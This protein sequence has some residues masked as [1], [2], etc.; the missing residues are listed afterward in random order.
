[1][2]EPASTLSSCYIK[3]MNVSIFIW[4]IYALWIILVAYLTVAAI[5]VKQAYYE[6]LEERFG[7][8]FIIIAAFL[9]PHLPIFNILNFTPDP[10]V[11]IIGVI[12]CIVGMV[13]LTWGRQSLGMNWSPTVA[14][15]KGQKLVTTG[16]Y[17]FVRN[18]IYSG[19]L[20]AA[21]GSAIVVG[22]AFIFLLIFLTPLF[23]WRVGAEDKLMEQQFSK[24]FSK[25]KKKTK[26][27]IPFVW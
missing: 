21:I 18:P 1:M 2:F 15:K 23:L 26:V 24:E 7:L 3:T 27:L 6:N 9:L 20:L 19:G 14:A 17:R 10:I 12:L 16:P 25:Y 4:L 8:M 5:G 13:F 22:G 11:G